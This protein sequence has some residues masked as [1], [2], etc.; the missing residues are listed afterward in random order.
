MAYCSILMYLAAVYLQPGIKYPALAPFR[1]VVVLGVFAIVSGTVY[2]VRRQGRPLIFDRQLKMMFIILLFMGVSVL[3]AYIK[4]LA[5]EEWVAFAKVVVF[6]VFLVNVVDSV[7]KFKGLL[8]VLI[9]IHVGVAI[10]G[11]EGFYTESDRGD[12]EGLKGTLSNFLG[13]TNDF[14][15][16][17]NVMIPYT[18]FLAFAT[19][20]VWVRIFLLGC[21][22]LFGL[23]SMFTFSRG[24]F[25]TLAALLIYFLLKSEKK[26]G[27]LIVSGALALLT[28]VVLPQSYWERMQTIGD[29]QSDGNVQTR[30]W[31]WKAGWHMALD[32]PIIGM[33]PRNFVTGYRVFYRPPEASPRRLYAAHS[34]YFQIMGELGFVGL[35]LLGRLVVITF[36]DQRQTLDAYR[37]GEAESDDGEFIRAASHATQASLL[38]FLIGGAFLSAAY[39]PHLWFN[40]ALTQILAR[41]ALDDLQ[42]AR[43]VERIGSPNV[44][45][46]YQRA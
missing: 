29:Y 14:A 6:T 43:A 17:I 41:T 37:A 13:D 25:V 22:G 44:T 12:R 26:L 3:G 15:L 9:L 33:G 36:R 20:R 28:L 16:A 5:Y 32:H 31:A 30:F 24:G 38:A 19:R 40:A 21:L 46:A 10:E 7:P 4:I 27:V 11:L 45:P 1:P 2:L 18:Y 42:R 39:Y 23:A 34:I 8:Y 35:A